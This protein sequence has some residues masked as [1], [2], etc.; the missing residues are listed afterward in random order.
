MKARHLKHILL[1]YRMGKT[2][3]EN[4]FVCSPR[5]GELYYDEIFLYYDGPCLFSLRNI[6]GYRFIAI[7]EREDSEHSRYVIAPVSVARYKAFV[8][9]RYSI[10]HVFTK[11]EMG[12]VFAAEFNQHGA[13]LYDI[14]ADE[15]ENLNLPDDAEMLEYNGSYL[16]NEIVY[17]ASEFNVP[18]IQKSLEKHGE[19]RQYIY[20]REF[21]RESEGFQR[22]FD[23]I[24][25]DAIQAI[26]EEKCTPKIKKRIKE[27]CQIPLMKTY[28]AS[29]GVQIEGIEFASLGEDESDF[30]KHIATYFALLEMGDSAND[31]FYVQHKHAIVALR[32]YYKTLLSLGFDVKLQAAT[33]AHKY[34]KSYLQKAT[35]LERYQYLNGIIGID[36]EQLTLVGTWS[37]INIDNKTFKFK[38]KSG[39]MVAGSFDE[40]FDESVF[41]FES[42]ISV[43]VDKAISVA[44]AGDESEKY[45][46]LSIV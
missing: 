6:L 42:E 24:A 20:A 13:H 8:E 26:P 5:Y 14:A 21:A 1:R 39:E 10:R 41:D 37:E 27:S 33:P 11:S 28:A 25:K 46:L 23:G 40:D 18:I 29:F 7:L 36:T 15:L 16:R 43:I 19:H 34:Y 31:D 38:C 4:S 3:N 2:M 45:T 35:I 44:R 17:N 22:I 30:C 12:G 9:N 32:K